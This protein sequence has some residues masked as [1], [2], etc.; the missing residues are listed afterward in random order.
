MM[1]DPMS[2]K[3]VS[4][5]TKVVLE[6]GFRKVT[7]DMI[8]KDLGISKKTLYRFFRTKE[9]LIAEVIRT[10][11]QN[12][13]AHDEEVMQSEASWEEKINQI[14]FTPKTMRRPGNIMLDELIQYYPEEYLR[15]E[16]IKRDLVVRIMKEEIGNG[17]IR[18]DIDPEIVTM[19]FTNMNEHLSIDDEFLYQNKLNL[20]ETLQMVA[21]VILNGIK[22]KD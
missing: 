16:K 19:I 5:A 15:F 1:T 12:M 6:K 3:I 18:P 22:N 13:K 21:D 17:S 2:G 4:H 14:I 11:E 10:M 7:V 9:E 20:V 8:C